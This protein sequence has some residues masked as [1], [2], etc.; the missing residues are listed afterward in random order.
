MSY[1]LSISMFPVDKGDSLSQYVSKISQIIHES[2]LSYVITPMATMIESDEIDPLLEII[3][4]GL[5]TMQQFS[6]RIYVNMALDYRNSPHK[7]R[8]KQKVES[9]QSKI[10]S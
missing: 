5:E 2:G 7:N 3:K 8:L 9:L 1:I 4:K 10:N 6:N